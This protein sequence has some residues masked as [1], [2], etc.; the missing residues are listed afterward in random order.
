MF[1]KKNN[2]PATILAAIAI[3]ALILAT[4]LLWTLLFVFNPVFYSHLQQST[5][6]ESSPVNKQLI[7][8]F[9]SPSFEP[10]AVF[11]L[12]FEERNHLLDVKKVIYSAELFL[13]I[14]LFFLFFIRSQ[15]SSKTI[16]T[17]GTALVLLPL[18]FLLSPF[19]WVFVHFHY[20]FFPQGNWQLD[21][22][23]TTLVNIY[24]E[25]FFQHF[26]QTIVLFTTITGAAFIFYSRNILKTRD[27]NTT[28]I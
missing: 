20:L 17:A 1:L 21:P 27:L 19:N 14:L 25:T 4:Y 26:L 16:H 12:S 13:S 10:P 2:F 23:T 28:N 6:Q 15:L 18:L 7:A 11:F 24:P 3:I 5:G 8:Y 9:L 22:A